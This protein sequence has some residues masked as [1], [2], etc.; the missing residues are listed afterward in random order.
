MPKIDE[1]FNNNWQHSWK[2]KIFKTND[3]LL[4]ENFMDATH[5][6]IAHN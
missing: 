1:S 3:D 2:K 4:I 6:P 5:T